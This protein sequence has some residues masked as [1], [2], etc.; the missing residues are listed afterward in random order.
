MHRS[1][2]HAVLLFVL[3]V[4]PF[5]QLNVFGSEP[6]SQAENK[7]AENSQK[8]E[9]ASKLSGDGSFDMTEQAPVVTQH[10][11][12]IA[13]KALHYTATAGRL[14]L[15]DSDGNIE[16]EMFFVAYTVDSP[17]A[18]RPL[19]FAF[20]GGPGSSSVWL[21]LG[22]LGPRRVV[23]QQDGFLPPPPYK[24][25][26]NPDT[27][28]DK[29]DLVLVDAVGTG[30]SRAANNDKAKG[31][32]N[33]NSDIEAFGKFI[34]LYLTRYDRWSSPL[35]LM[36]ESYGTTRAA[37]VAGYLTDKGVSFNGIVLLSSVLNF[38][39]L[40]FTK[41]NDLPYILTLPSYTMIAF[42]HKKLP[43]ELLQDAAKTREE[44]ER[45]ATGEYA[46]ALFKGD[47]ISAEERQQVIDHMARYTGL[48]KQTLDQANLRVDV[49]E[50]T[51]NLLIDK[52]L[53]VGRFDG[54]FTGPDP[55]S[56]LETSYYDP[57][58]AEPLPPFTSVFNNYIKT[59]LNYKT[60]VPYYVVGWDVGGFKWDWGTAIEGFP[61]TAQ[62]LRAAIVKNRYL[63]VLFAEGYYDL[64]TPYFEA[65]YT[66]NHLDL[67]PE[68]R[69][70]VSFTTYD[71]GHMAY[72]NYDSRVKLKKDIADFI[73]S[74]LQ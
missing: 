57:S 18:R 55:D 31:F 8:Q 27:V 17:A 40:V 54:R 52:K 45:W 43:P 56:L 51:H 34:Q 50:F 67:A 74:A 10:E 36:G 62:K 53:T 6:E 20:N 28:L 71:S 23:V 5:S 69:K 1:I 70:N 16:A 48:S 37:G 46:Q 9:K 11:I 4:L 39:T 63:K 21:H 73:G 26:D 12:T 58:L 24:I 2:L 19:M 41:G 35:Y 66:I 22:I 38:Q 29:T 47:E 44:A 7:S 32:W 68:Y 30:F 49:R 33:V 65:N 60:E 42:Y 15:K 61:S 3:S 59:E 25:G 64:A 72:L 14:P 13:G